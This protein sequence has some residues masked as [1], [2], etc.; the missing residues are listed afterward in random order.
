MERRSARRRGPARCHPSVIGLSRQRT[1]VIVA[2]AEAA[3]AARLY[4]QVL[5][6]LRSLTLCEPLHE[7]AH[8]L[9]MIALAG[10]GRQAAAL[11]VFAAGGTADEQLGVRP[12][13]E[14]PGAHQRVLRQQIPVASKAAAG[15]ATSFQSVR[16]GSDTPQ[17]AAR[18]LPPAPSNFAGRSGELTTLTGLM[19]GAARSDGAVVILVIGGGAGV[20][21]TALALHW[22][23]RV[24][25]QFPD[26][27]LYVNLCG[28]APQRTPWPPVAAMRGFL[29]AL[30][31]PPDRIP[32]GLDAGAA[33]YRSL[34]ADRRALIVLD[35]ACDCDQVRPLLP[36]SPAC[37][38]LVTSRNRLTGLVAADGA[39]PLMLDVLGEHEAQE[40]LARRLGPDRVAAEPQAARNL[41]RLCACLPLALSVIAARAAVRPC[42]SLGALADQLRNAPSRLD[43]LDTEEAATSVRAAFARSVQQLSDSAAHMFAL[44]GVRAGTEISDQAAASLAGVPLPAARAALDELVGANLLGEHSRGRYAFTTC[45]GPTPPNELAPSAGC[46]STPRVGRFGRG[47]FA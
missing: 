20:G 27:Q 5:E 36:G 44:L 15:A 34:L 13:P 43:A 40:L 25:G 33:L 29:D 38:V 26:G 19:A 10:S 28:F 18:Q 1:A 4:S 46:R 7:R 37:L 22:A 47:Q 39:H 42:L 30:H 45:S 2:Y 9:Y 35:D 23:H 16:D 31:I 32:P 3:C 6:H 17:R 14:L 8:A 11:E 41:V 12:C 21:K 24:A